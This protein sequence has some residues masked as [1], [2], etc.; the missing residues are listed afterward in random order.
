MRNS[1]KNPDRKQCKNI[2]KSFGNNPLSNYLREYRREFL[3][4]G[5]DIAKCFPGVNDV[6]ISGE[7]FKLSLGEIPGDIPEL[8]PVEIPKENP[9]EINEEFPGEIPE[10]KSERII[11][12]IYRSNSEGI[13]TETMKESLIESRQEYYISVWNPGINPGRNS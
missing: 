10:E 5:E 9:L 7:I 2:S 1:K 4:K 11:K 12:R 8:L 13:P 6:R 3:R